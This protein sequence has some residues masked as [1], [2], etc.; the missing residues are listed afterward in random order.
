MTVKH[1]KHHSLVRNGFEN[2]G[3]L[4]DVELHM[5]KLQFTALNLREVEKV[6]DHT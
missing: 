5:L 1:T 3:K 4:Y 2:N 6:I